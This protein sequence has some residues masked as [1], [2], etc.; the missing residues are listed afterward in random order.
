MF[1]DLPLA[2][3]RANRQAAA[4]HFA[5]GGQVRCDTVEF[6][7]ATEGDTEAGHDLIENQYRA[8]LVAYLPQRFKE[9]G[10]RRYAVH[11]ARHWLNDD[12]CDFIAHFC[13]GFPNTFNIVERQGQRMFREAGGNAR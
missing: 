1:H 7:S 3:K 6:L 9:T 11:V 2:A 10:D 4:N 8:V 5:Q 13:E 12:G